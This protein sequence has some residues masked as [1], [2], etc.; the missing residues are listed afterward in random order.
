MNYISLFSS[1]GVGCYGF[2]REK[3]YCIASNELISKRLDIQKINKISDSDESYIL[4]D[5]N[6]PDVQKKLFK[7]VEIDYSRKKIKEIDVIISTPPCQGISV[8]NLKKKDETK[9]NSLV[10]SSIQI[11][12]KL[13][14]RFFIFENVQ[15]FMK[16]ICTDIDG[17]NK[18]IEEAINLNLGGNYNIISK[19]INFKD[20]GA[21]SSRTRTMVIG[22]RIDL[23][24]ITPYDI[25]PKKTK[26]RT[27]KETI[28]HLKKLKKMGSIDPKDIYHQFKEY[29]PHMESWIKDLKE[30]E[31]AFDNIEPQ[32]IPHRIIN[33]KYVKNKNKNS[34]KYKRTFWTKPAPCIHT[35][36]D[37]LASQNT[38]HPEE[39]RV[40]SI[41]E[42]MLMMN[43]PSEF[44]WIKNEFKELNNL[45][46]NEKIIILKNNQRNIRQCIGESVP[47]IIF[48]S[49][50]KKI[51]QISKLKRLKKNEINKIIKENN[52]SNSDSLLNFL[53]SR[54]EE[55]HLS[56]ILKLCELSN[57]KRDENAAF[58][59]RQ[60]LCFDLMNKLPDF[61][62]RKKIKILEPSVG[63]GNF[64]PLIIAKY[65]QINQV[66]LDLVDID[67][68]VQKILKALIQMKLIKIPKNFIVNF[69]CSDFLI[70]HNKK[71]D[72]IIGNP[73]F[74]KL[75]HKKELLTKYKASAIN[76]KTNNIFSF[77][78]E[79]SIQNSK[80]IF[81]ILPKS[82]LSSPEFQITRD[83]VSKKNIHSIFDYGE[84]GFRGVLIETIGILIK[85]KT[86]NRVNI[87]SYINNS[88]RIV[89]QKYIINEKFPNWLIY[90]NDF[91]DSISKNIEFNV[92]EVF[93]DRSI[94]KRDTKSK[95]KYRVIKSR[96]I[97]NLEIINIKDYDS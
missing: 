12:K 10:V 26:A 57:L 76:K 31:S 20:Y 40:F 94:T 27:L 36:N 23:E 11:I 52:L 13:K 4:G 62:N 5:I 34:D 43:I 85:D 87:K 78:L 21:S 89:D 48:E 2:K 1:A 22:S 69:I 32:K 55:F 91:F 67:P 47:T 25:F 82:F 80:N 30:G 61:K 63:F 37:I 7:K 84:K 38:I 72:L 77:F 59:T 42:L 90:R 46:L 83:A 41:R 28:G 50:A 3:F 58:S 70:E 14:P 6:N 56:S 24:E 33:G 88:Y 49:I 65:S 74:G 73:P 19:V 39:N 92:F 29:P 53:E 45:E 66:E 93:R 81:F 79:K 75:T 60:D 71:Y 8:A 16:T 9:R 15:S 95:G 64:I 44:K 97:S 54:S 51:K 17:N 18:T 35:R 68:N 96:N 86:D